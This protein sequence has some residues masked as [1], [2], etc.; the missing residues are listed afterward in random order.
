[1]KQGVKKSVCKHLEENEVIRNN[2]HGVIKIKLCL[3]NLLS[4]YVYG[5]V[6][7]YMDR[8]VKLQ[9]LGFSSEQLGF[10]G[11]CSGLMLFTIF[12]NVLE[13]WIECMLGKVA[14]DTKLVWVKLSCRCSGE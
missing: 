9:R 6:I 4:F 10:P 14:D 5:K 3:T 11:I 8:Y 12:I 2:Q 13:D 1:M 7:D